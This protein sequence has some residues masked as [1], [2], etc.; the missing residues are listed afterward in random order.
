MEIINPAPRKNVLLGLP[1]QPNPIRASSHGL[2]S[3]TNKQ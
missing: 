3:L 1:K 2:A